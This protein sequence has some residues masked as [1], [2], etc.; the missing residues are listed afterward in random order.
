MG[1]LGGDLVLRQD[2]G[3]MGLVPRKGH[4]R[5]QWEG[6]H[7]QAR[8]WVCSRIR[9]CCLL[10][11]RTPASR[12][13]RKPISAASATQPMAFFHGSQGGL[14][15][16]LASVVFLDPALFSLQ[17]TL[18][19]ACAPLWASVHLFYLLCALLLPCRT[20]QP[21]YRPFGR[22]FGGVPVHLII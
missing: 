9:L 12:A 21:R 1:P 3:L 14:S 17:Y 7:L 5:I 6:G 16:T 4:T 10:D 8:R 20:T 11:L 22:S 18:S 2:P 19:R 15:S 13:V